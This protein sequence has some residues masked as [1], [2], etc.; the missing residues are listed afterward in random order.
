MH[1]LVDYSGSMNYGRKTKK[2]EYAAMIG[3]GFCYMA[4]KNNERFIL[5]TFAEK[6]ETFKPRKG[7]GQLGAAVDYLVNKRSE[8]VTNFEDCITQYHKLMVKS[9]SMVIIISDFL[10]PTQQIQN[11]LMRFKDHDIY[12]IQVLDEQELNL[13]MEGDFKLVDAETKTNMRTFITPYLRKTYQGALEGH[14][15][16]IKQIATSIRGHYFTVGTDK[17][18]FDTFYLI[19]GGIRVGQAQRSPPERYKLVDVCGQHLLY[20][21]PFLQVIN[22][23]HQYAQNGSVG[24]DVRSTK[25]LDELNSTLWTTLK[26]SHETLEMR[27]ENFKKSQNDNPGDQRVLDMS[28]LSWICSKKS[29]RL[30]T[31]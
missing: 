12:L 8:S 21:T 10:Y 15:G 14:I 28:K 13:T 24:K 16:K 3:L 26:D 2:S 7:R 17:E 18:L 29:I 11:A 6:I 25:Y 5:S 31:S 23:P 1:I 19:F 9:R 4:M 22:I 20:S 30:G 27:I